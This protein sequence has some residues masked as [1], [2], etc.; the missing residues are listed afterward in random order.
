MN[1]STPVEKIPGIGLKYQKR[2]NRLGIKTLGELLFYFPHHYGDFSKITKIKEIKLNERSCFKGKILEIKQ[3][4]T[5][6]RK[7]ILTKAIVEND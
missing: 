2:L 3:E 7:I 1:F 5:W 4:R 6:K